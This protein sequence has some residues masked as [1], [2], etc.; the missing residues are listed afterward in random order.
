MILAY[1]LVRWQSS[2]R[3]VKSFWCCDVVKIH[4][5]F[6]LCMFL[7][8]H[9]HICISMRLFPWQ[10]FTGNM[11]IMLS[12]LFLPPP[13]F[14]PEFTDSVVAA[15]L[16]TPSSLPLSWLLQHLHL[17]VS[18]IVM[19]SCTFIH[20][21]AYLQETVTDLAHDI[22]VINQ[23]LHGNG[24]LKHE[25]LTSCVCPCVYFHFLLLAS[26]DNKGYM[27]NFL[28]PKVTQGL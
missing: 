18:Q 12:P 17:I 4:V 26:G 8:L 28:S 21:L 15:F 3:A 23:F 6:Y 1:Y 7:G 9:K 5:L 16:P 27:R 20:R 22:S 19:A 11:Q 14:V 2:L 13:V 25:G 24:E 10:H